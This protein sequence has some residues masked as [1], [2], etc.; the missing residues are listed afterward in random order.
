MLY[1]LRKINCCVC[2]LRM[3]QK[4][5]VFRGKLC[6]P[7]CKLIWHA[8]LLLFK[9]VTMQFIDYFKGDH[10]QTHFRSHFEI[11]KCCGY[12]EYKVKVI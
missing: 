9:G 8:R 11:T 2:V 7:I 3:K 4:S 1:M 6:P 12:I 5:N 10:A